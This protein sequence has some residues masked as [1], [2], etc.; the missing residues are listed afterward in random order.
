MIYKG[1]NKVGTIY[2]GA[3]KVGKIYKGLELVY[4]SAPAVD[5]DFVFTI[6]GNSYTI[7]T[8]NFL[9]VYNFTIN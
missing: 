2:S 7:I 1:N 3:D 9:G 6:R 5:P 4:S 8:L